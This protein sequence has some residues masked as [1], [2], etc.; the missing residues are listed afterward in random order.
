MKLRLN[1][2]C[3]DYAHTDPVRSGVVPVEGV[4]LNYIVVG[5]HELFRRQAN[6]AE[7]DAAEFSL[8]TLMILCSRGD[9][10]FVGI[11]VFPVHRFR[12]RSIFVNVDAGIRRPEDLKGRRVGVLEFVQTAG[13][14]VRGFLHH[15]FGIKIEDIEWYIGG[16]DQPEDDYVERIPVSLPDRIRRHQIP[17]HKSLDRMLEAGEIDAAIVPNAPGSFIRRSPHV[18]RLFPNYLAV[19]KEYFVR[20]GI[21]PIMHTLVLKRE[22][23]EKT[24]WVA[25][26]LFKAFTR[27]KEIVSQRLAAPAGVREYYP[28]PW[29]SEYVQSINELMGEHVWAYGLKENKKTLETLAEYALEQSLLERPVVIKELFAEETHRGA[30]FGRI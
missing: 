6:Y 30:E 27:A 5:S 3:G 11:P 23:Y 25:Q 16:L 21:F 14:W 29:L 12:H 22:I 26:S 4:D 1:L 20:T 7:F 18:K 13:V 2:A 19:E 10:R 17:S 8:S 24:P 15:D 9:T 28:I